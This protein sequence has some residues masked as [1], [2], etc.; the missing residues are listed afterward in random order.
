MGLCVCCYLAA[1]E[2]FNFCLLIG[3]RD[4]EDIVDQAEIERMVQEVNDV[5]E[6]V[7]EMNVAVETTIKDLRC[8]ADYLD[9]VWKD[10]K[11]A[12]AAGSSA[13]ILGGL[14]TLGGGV[15]IVMTAGVAGVAAPLFIAG[16]AIGAAGSCTNLGASIVEASINSSLIQAAD[17]AVENAN[18]AINNVREKI[19][20]LKN[21]KNQARL[22][23][24]AGLAARMLGP[25]HLAVTL[26]QGLLRPDLLSKVLSDYGTKAVSQLALRL[27]VTEAPT[28]ATRGL[29]ETSSREA[30]SI[31]VTTGARRAGKTGAVTVQKISKRI[32]TRVSK[33]VG[34]RAGARA[35]SKAGSKTASNAGNVVKEGSNAVGNV[36]T[37]AG[38]KVAGEIIMGVSA[39]FL[40]LDALELGFTV[41]DIVNNKGSDAARCLRDRADELEEV[42]RA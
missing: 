21:G 18:R 39:A 3:D 12:S 29:I 2:Y 9:Q 5:A 22:L 27:G 28:V 6:N 11:F 4:G 13:G 16:T 17:G 8:T 10:C 36:G 15:A 33:K 30:V 25:N 35:L 23:F 34:T 1:Y 42:L 14:L 32:T 26:I 24:V 31:G 20:M 40:I 7:Q 38:A 41:R 19:R 37:K